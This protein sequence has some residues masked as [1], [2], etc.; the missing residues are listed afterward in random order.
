LLHDAQGVESL[1]LTVQV[2][3]VAEQRQGLP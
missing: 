1:S 3:E 2:A